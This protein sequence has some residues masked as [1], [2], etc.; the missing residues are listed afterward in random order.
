MCRSYYHECPW[1]TAPDCHG[2]RFIRT[3]RCR[4]QPAANEGAC[5]KQENLALPF[6]CLPCRLANGLPEKLTN[7]EIAERKAITTAD[8]R[9]REAGRGTAYPLKGPLP[10]AAP[11]PQPG[12]EATEPTAAALNVS[13]P[14]P[15]GGVTAPPV[16][17]PEPPTPFETPHILEPY[18]RDLVEFVG[19][20]NQQGWASE[21][22]R[23]PAEANPFA[24]TEE[25]IPH[26]IPPRPAQ[27]RESQSPQPVA[28]TPAGDVHPWAD[29]PTDPW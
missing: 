15:A 5:Q 18:E 14:P 23:P 7:G 3:R 4:D 29:P 2:L 20:F 19:A 1:A 24:G 6:A 26:H 22:R 8:G 21:G 12:S 10:G 28:R 11:A 25:T 27:G 13:A 16:A 9:R 17:Q